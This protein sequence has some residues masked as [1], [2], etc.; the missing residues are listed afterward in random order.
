MKLTASSMTSTHKGEDGYAFT[1]D[2]S[3]DPGSG[4]S[5]NV[6]MSAHGRTT[7]EAAI[8]HLRHSAEAFLR[9]LDKVEEA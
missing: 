4:W 6:S 2:A 3:H 9:A 7:P 1:V 5:A 8:K